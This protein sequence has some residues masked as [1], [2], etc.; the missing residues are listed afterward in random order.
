[1]YVFDIY[2]DIKLSDSAFS[3]MKSRID[4]DDEENNG[5]PKSMPS[6]EKT[7]TT[8]SIKVNKPTSTSIN[9][10]QAL[11]NVSEYMK[12]FIHRKINHH[13]GL[14][15]FAIGSLNNWK[16]SHLV[17]TMHYFPRKQIQ[18]EQNQC[19]QYDHRMLHIASLF[20]ISTEYT[21]NKCER[22]FRRNFR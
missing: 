22:L 19:I 14:K 2:L 18:V 16:M 12:C 13:Y 4:D 6:I 10:R 3:A 5:K 20:R 9:L 1:M 7:S 11:V 17:R 8:K 15:R 21:F